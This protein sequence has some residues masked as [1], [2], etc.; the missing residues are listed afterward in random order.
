MVLYKIP[1]WIP[2][3]FV[4]LLSSTVL[5]SSGFSRTFLNRSNCSSFN[6]HIR[7]SSSMV[8]KVNTPLVSGSLL[9]L[10]YSLQTNL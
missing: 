4:I 10:L 6:C 2:T 9:L 7:I 1:L 8:T 5:F 3:S